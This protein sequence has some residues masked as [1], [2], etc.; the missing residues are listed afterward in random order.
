MAPWRGHTWGRGCPGVKC[1]TDPCGSAPATEWREEGGTG[2]ATSGDTY[3]NASA[4]QSA[5]HIISWVVCGGN[6]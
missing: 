6:V 4:T 3:T 5:L 1:W 2:V